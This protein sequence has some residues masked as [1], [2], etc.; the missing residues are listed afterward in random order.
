MPSTYRG[1]TL[2]NAARNQCRQI[3]ENLRQR[4]PAGGSQIFGPPLG[5]KFFLVMAQSRKIVKVFPVSEDKCPQ[6]VPQWCQRPVFKSGKR[7][8]AQVEPAVPLFLYP[9]ASG[10]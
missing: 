2:F 5:I 9:T 8:H 1:W 6:A 7:R 4:Q 3:G 10:K